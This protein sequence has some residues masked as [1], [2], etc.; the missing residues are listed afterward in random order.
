MSV[1]RYKIL[2]LL[3]KEGPLTS[4]QI[5]NKLKTSRQNVTGALSRLI[6]KGYVKRAW[7]TKKRRQTGVRKLDFIM[8]EGGRKAPIYYLPHQR[9]IVARMLIKMLKK[10]KNSDEKRSMIYLIKNS[11]L[12]PPLE[13]LLRKWVHGKHS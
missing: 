9:H 1:L 13:D 7:L 12:E 6:T 4:I 2:Y 10:P 5:A 3:E 11:E 8:A